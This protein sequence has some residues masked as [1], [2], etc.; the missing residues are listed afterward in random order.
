M[1][2]CTS[3][4]ATFAAAMEAADSH[5]TDAHGVSEPVA[6]AVVIDLAAYRTTTLAALVVAGAPRVGG[7]AA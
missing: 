6:L 2:P 3:R 1:W 7:E 4:E 5:L